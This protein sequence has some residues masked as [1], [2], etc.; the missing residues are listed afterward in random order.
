MGR[1]GSQR[2]SGGAVG[3]REAGWCQCLGESRYQQKVPGS[4]IANQGIFNHRT[5][6]KGGQVTKVGDV[7]NPRQPGPLCFI[8]VGRKHSAEAL[9]LLLGSNRVRLGSKMG[10][11]GAFC[12][13]QGQVAQLSYMTNRGDPDAFPSPHCLSRLPPSAFASFFSCDGSCPTNCASPRERSWVLSGLR[14]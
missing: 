14:C 9:P 1:E 8:A 5:T 2:S 6:I 7:Q 3:A 13:T 10:V 11:L 4:D 12:R